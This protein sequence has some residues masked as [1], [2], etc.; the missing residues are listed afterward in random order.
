[1]NETPQR[2]DCPYVGLQPFEEQHQAYF[3]GREREQRLIISNLLAAPLTILYGSSGVGK[4]SVLMAGVIPQLRR[5]RP[6]TP[7]IMFRSW[8]RS[9]CAEMLA[10]AC[11][12]ATWEGARD[13]PRPSLSMPLDEILRACAEAAHA[14]VLVILDQF[15]EYFLYHAKTSDPDS[16]E[17]A[18]ARAVNREDVDVGFLIALRE[19]GLAK[20]DRFNERIPNLLGNRLRLEH[21]DEEGAAVAI[22]KPL[23]VW[24]DRGTPGEPPVEIEGALVD[25]LIEQVRIG[26]VSVGRGAGGGGSGEEVHVVEAPF[27]QLVL[28]RLWA[29]EVGKGSRV[30][31]LSTLDGLKGA[32]AIVGRHLDQ[33][34]DQLDAEKQAV[35]ASFFDRLV[36]P[37]GSKIACS[38]TDLLGWAGPLSGQVAAVLDFLSSHEN[39]ILRPVAGPVDRADTTF[40]EIFHDVLAPAILDWSARYT[41]AVERDRAVKE[42]HEAA[43]KR[44][45]RRRFR[46]AVALLSIAVF[47]CA[48]AIYQWQEAKRARRQAEAN[49]KAAEAILASASD[50]IGAL[51]LALAAADETLKANEGVETRAEEA[52]RWTVQTSRLDRTLDLGRPVFDLAYHPVRPWLAVGTEATA[53]IWDLQTHRRIGLIPHTERV[54]RVAFDTASNRLMTAAGKSAYLWSLDD[55]ETP[56]MLMQFVHGDPLF[57]AV[58]LS[59]DGLWLAT[60]GGSTPPGD[61]KRLMKIWDVTA[62]SG[63]PIQVINLEGAWVMGLDFTPDGCCIATAAVERGSK[64]RSWNEI[65]SIASGAKILSVP[66]TGPGDAVTF[67]PDGK[68]L[69]TGNRDDRVRVWRPVVRELDAIIDERAAQSARSP[70]VKPAGM[71]TEIPPVPVEPEPIL[72]TVRVLAGHVDRIRNVAVDPTGT[73]LASVGADNTARVWDAETGESLVTLVG[74]RKWIEGVAFSPDGQK[75]LTGGRD[76]QVRIWDVASHTG[77]VNGIAFSHDG[78]SLATASGDRTVKVWNVGEDGLALRWTLTGHTD[79]VYRV[80]F[81]PRGPRLVSVGFDN[82]V[83][84]W[85]VGLGQELRGFS[86]HR[87]QLRDVAFSG[88][89]ALLA[90][91]AADG[92]A[93]LW[94][95]A[96]ADRPIATVS[97]NEPQKP[98]QVHTVTFHPDGNRWVTAG[99]DGTIRSWDFQGQELGRITV[100]KR[101]GVLSMALDRDGG[102]IA[103]VTANSRLYLWPIAAMTPSQDIPPKEPKECE[104]V[105]PPPCA[106]VAFS[107]DGRT[108]AV[109]C[110]DN[111]VRLF[112]AASCKETKS[113]NVH[114]DFVNDAVFSPDG[115]YLASASRDRRFQV[116]PL[117]VEDLLAL[118]RRKLALQEH[119]PENLR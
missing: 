7:V 117:S 109:A 63:E 53:E 32:A 119:A 42:A 50:P 64:G 17:V 40:Y 104:R 31:R 8:A 107:P 55:P 57:R 106:A 14:T 82:T 118:A 80:A 74:H 52:L 16:F 81:D 111:T 28:Q 93:M 98:T 91:A 20:L 103:A 70:L 56:Q 58:A 105:K 18:F 83:R 61:S 5:D 84:L 41:Q 92:T 15:E 68:A 46:V 79:T 22:R 10:S 48:V 37:G 59:R 36:T 38:K 108:L 113:I 71:L 45:Q 34:I 90:T 77:S 47:C 25:R 66:S 12:E 96:G 116:S 114:L 110:H 67:T 29:E 11:V 60:A 69:V 72:W 27:L 13:Q 19:D 85:D 102:T 33:V 99:L 78:K 97:H 23:A 75:L 30:L 54:W 112:D 62:H 95:I 115:K 26:Q 101:A 88:D 86:G 73:R 21:L 94:R 76:G 43:N 24:N 87:D 2:P 100:P 51:R 35:C 6:K 39:R 1:M 89:G 4:S 49:R 3:F 65:W 9:D 44:F